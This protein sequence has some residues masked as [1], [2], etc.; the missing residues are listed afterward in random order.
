MLKHHSRSYGKYTAWALGK[1]PSSRARKSGEQLPKIGDKG[2]NDQQRSCGDGRHD[3]TEYAHTDG[4]RPHPR[5]ALD[6]PGEEERQRDDQKVWRKLITHFG[7]LG[8][9]AFEDFV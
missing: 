7:G 8:S 6:D 4:R 1:S 2:W 5:H 3:R 9:V